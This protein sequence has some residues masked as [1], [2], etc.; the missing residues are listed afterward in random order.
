MGTHLRVTPGPSGPDARVLVLSGDMD[1]DTVPRL[2]A[3]F[4]VELARVP[5]PTVLTVDCAQVAFCASAGLNEL[6]RA[7]LEAEAAGITLRLRAPARQMQRLLSITG[8]DTVF[9]IR[10]AADST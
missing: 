9:D 8:T 3:A 4:D 5:A 2:R 6:L 1:M 7:R 10:T